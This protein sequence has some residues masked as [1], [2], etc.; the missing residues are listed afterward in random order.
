MQRYVNSSWNRISKSFIKIGLV[1]W[2]KVK[3]LSSSPSAKIFFIMIRPNSLRHGTDSCVLNS[4][5]VVFMFCTLILSP[6]EESGR[7]SFWDYINLKIDIFILFPC[8]KTNKIYNFVYN[9]KIMKK[10]CYILWVQFSLDFAL[11]F[12]Y[13]CSMFHYSWA[14]PKI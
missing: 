4:S 11:K 13:S 7:E 14:F 8:F 10:H 2:L 5:T 9:N 1:E 12:L 6:T 3:A